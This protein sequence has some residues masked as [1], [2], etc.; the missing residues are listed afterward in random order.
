[1]QHSS[2]NA[3]V[4]LSA[5]AITSGNSYP[6]SVSSAKKLM[7]DAETDLKRSDLASRT[8]TAYLYRNDNPLDSDT[9]VDRIIGT[10]S[11]LPR[12]PQTSNIYLFIYLM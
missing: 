12:Q 10:W 7:N 5:T 9:D 2:Y 3:A 8:S 11:S 4:Q 6:A 1:M